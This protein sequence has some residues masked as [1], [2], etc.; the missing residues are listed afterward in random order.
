MTT[1]IKGHPHEIAV[2]DITGQENDV[3]LCAECGSLKS[4]L[5]LNRDRW[6]C[7]VCRN[8]GVVNP[9]RIPLTNPARRR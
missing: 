6:F 5:W 3:A 2:N 8:E 9:T 7:R 4:V 1:I